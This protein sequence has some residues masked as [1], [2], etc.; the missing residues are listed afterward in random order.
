MANAA[1]KKAAAG[2]LFVVFHDVLNVSF[3][4]LILIPLTPCPC[5]IA[6]RY[7]LWHSASKL[8]YRCC[9]DRQGVGPKVLPTV[10]AHRQCH[11]CRLAVLVAGLV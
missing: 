5:V 10:S 2:T 9:T 4:K 8:L 11:L 1:A 7:I 6:V 3:R